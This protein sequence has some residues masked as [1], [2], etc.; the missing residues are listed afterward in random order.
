MA[1]SHATLAQIMLAVNDFLLQGHLFERGIVK[2][3]VEPRHDKT[4][5]VT[6]RPESSLCA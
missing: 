3:V 6:V 1:Y 5:K 4:N 2:L